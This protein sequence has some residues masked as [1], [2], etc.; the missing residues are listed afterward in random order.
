MT[1]KRNHKITTTLKFRKPQNSHRHKHPSTHFTNAIRKNIDTL[2]AI[3]GDHNIISI[4]CDDKAR[5]PLGVTL[6]NKQKAILS[7]LEYVT[8][9]DHDFPYGKSHCFITSVHSVFQVS[10]NGHLNDY[11]RVNWFEPTSVFIRS[12]YHEQQSAYNRALDIG[13]MISDDRFKEYIK[14]DNG[15]KPILVI[16]GDGGP[17]EAVKNDKVQNA[18]L[19]LLH[20]FQFDAIYARNS[21][22]KNNAGNRIEGR[23][24]ILSDAMLGKSLPVFK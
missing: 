1:A 14:N 16:G 8:L 21:S 9:S 2:G 12:G 11:K 22:P 5:A 18:Y 24:V 15:V 7:G 17:D 3:L 13:T 4:E 10:I 20:K 19:W 6:A 23:M